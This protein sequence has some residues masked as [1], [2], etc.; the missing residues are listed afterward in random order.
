M[1]KSRC[2]YIVALASLFAFSCNKMIEI[3]DHPINQIPQSRVFNDSADIISAVAGVYSNF[4]ANQT[5][6]T[7][8]STMVTIIGGM[9][10][11]ELLANSSSNAGFISNNIPVNDG[12]VGNLWSGG[13][14]NLYQMNSCINGIGSTTAISDS[15]KHA[16][17]GE[18]K[19]ARAFYYF[20]LVNMFG[21]VP[22]ITSTDYN[23]TSKQGRASVD[24]V[25]GLIRADL[26]EARSVLK[27]KY[28]SSAGTKYRPNLYTALAL[29]AKVFLYRQQW[30][31]AAMMANQVI[32]DGLYQLE[33][34]PAT[35]FS[36]SSKEV[37]WTL[38]GNGTFVSTG[39][40]YTLLPFSIYSTPSYYLNPLLLSAFE[41]GDLRKT[42]WIRT[43]IVSGKT[44][45]CAQ[46]YKSNQGTSTATP[47]YPAEDYVMF[48]LAD[49]Y[50]VL[51]E[52][53]AQLGNTT[54]ARTNID[55]VRAR[56]G[57]PAYTGTDADLLTGI[58]HERQIE[59]AFEWGNRWYDLK[60][61]GTIDAVLGA[62]KPT[63]TSTAALLPIPSTQLVANVALTQNEGYN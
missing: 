35:V 31:S 44:Y 6:G 42:A 63:W 28:P 45:S 53:D 23:I 20:Q 32:N 8:G 46:K 62:E 40:G 60:R 41:D 18:M 29:S 30:D 50:L 57:L 52:A 14:S 39:E 2:I 4:K 59:M 26:A 33:S 47:T 43:L 1:K 61:T 12:N 22:L 36:K 38:P 56:A 10:A 37:I 15:L 16:L 34:T 24:E 49:M 54:D 21:G 48:R 51:A 5:G 19:V 13:Y 27:A 55:I 17:V 58:Y 7:I 25:Y 11:D 9:S 3:P